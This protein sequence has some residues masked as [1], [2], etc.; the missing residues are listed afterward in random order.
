MRSPMDRQKLEDK[1]DL[2]KFVTQATIAGLLLVIAVLLV[3]VG[4]ELYEQ[5]HKLH[6][7]YSECDDSSIR[8]ESTCTRR[9]KIYPDGT[10][11]RQYKDRTSRKWVDEVGNE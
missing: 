8:R 7:M 11:Q 10:Q 9:W 1:R 2:K 3:K 6:Y 4:I 5:K